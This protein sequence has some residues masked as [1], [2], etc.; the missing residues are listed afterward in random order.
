MLNASGWLAERLAYH[1]TQATPYEAV[2]LAYCVL[3][4]RNLA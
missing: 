4:S 3:Q 2:R 1:F